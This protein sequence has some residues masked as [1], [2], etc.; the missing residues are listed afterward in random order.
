MTSPREVS[1]AAEQ[2]QELREITF[3]EAIREALTEEMERAPAMII[4]GEDVTPGGGTFGVHQGIG[5]RF[6]GRLIEAP[7]SEAAIVG[8]ALGAALAG[9]PAV[10]EIMYSD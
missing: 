10:A 7:I 6:P 1:A 4:I 5:E 8:M 2:G 9:G 3:R